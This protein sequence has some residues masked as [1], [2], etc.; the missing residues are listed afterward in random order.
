[1]AILPPPM[2]YTAPTLGSVSKTAKTRPRM[3]R[4]GHAVVDLDHG[5]VR[6]VR[7]VCSSAA[8]QLGR[9]VRISTSADD[10]L[11]QY[12]TSCSIPPAC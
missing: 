12:W 9:L 8:G 6:I 7:N 10:P 2:E 1:M 5:T 3:V 4:L 11:Q